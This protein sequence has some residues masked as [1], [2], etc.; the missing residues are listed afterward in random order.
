MS[1]IPIIGG[2]RGTVSKNLEK[3]FDEL[4]IRGRFETIQTSK[5]ETDTEYSP[6]GLR[7]L[8]LTQTLVKGH[9]LKLV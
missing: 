1:V 5:I 3:K 4:E 8:V 9:Q 6:G 2:T 7:K